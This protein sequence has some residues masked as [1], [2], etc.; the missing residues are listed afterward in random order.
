MS[1]EIINL[2]FL[3]SITTLFMANLLLQKRIDLLKSFV[4]DI[5]T[6]TIKMLD[7]VVN[8]ETK[9]TKK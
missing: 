6:L 2:A 4:F 5:I 1:Q 8:E 9:K 3:L 7:G